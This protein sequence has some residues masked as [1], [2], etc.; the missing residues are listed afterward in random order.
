[1]VSGNSLPLESSVFSDAWAFL[2]AI[3]D[4]EGTEED[5]EKIL[6]ESEKIYRK[7]ENTPC[8]QLASSL[9]NDVMTHVERSHKDGQ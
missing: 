9:L 6:E 4:T 1:M 7:Y 8:S 5:W 3:Y 2:K